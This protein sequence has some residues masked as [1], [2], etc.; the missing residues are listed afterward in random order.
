MELVDVCGLSKIYSTK[1]VVDA[2]QYIT[3]IM[4][5]NKRSQASKKK[6]EFVPGVFYVHE[7]H[8]N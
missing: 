3:H 2:L 5:L 4:L 8:Q 1:T 6:A 7:C